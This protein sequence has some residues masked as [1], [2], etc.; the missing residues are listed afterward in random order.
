MVGASLSVR[1]YK[2]MVVDIAP[3]LEPAIY[4]GSGLLL[5]AAEVQQSNRLMMHIWCRA[6]WLL[7]AAV[8]QQGNRLML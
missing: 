5:R 3:K 2:K 6:V 4:T 1:L 8:V 7:C